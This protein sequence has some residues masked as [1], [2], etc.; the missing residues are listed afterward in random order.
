[1]EEVGDRLSA[2]VGTIDP[3]LVSEALVQ[4]LFRAVLSGNIEG[5]GVELLNQLA[6]LFLTDFGVSGCE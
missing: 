2:R 1:M 5:A 6:K 4:L 3:V